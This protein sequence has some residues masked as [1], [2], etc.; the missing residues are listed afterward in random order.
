MRFQN[1]IE[2]AVKDAQRKAAV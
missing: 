1:L 2:S